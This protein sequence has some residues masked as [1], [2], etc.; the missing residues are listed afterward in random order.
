MYSGML[1]REDRRRR[2]EPHLHRIVHNMHDNTGIMRYKHGFMR[3]KRVSIEAV[4]FWQACMTP[5]ARNYQP[6]TTSP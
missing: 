6:V 5:P 3:Y 2:S 4:R 1:R